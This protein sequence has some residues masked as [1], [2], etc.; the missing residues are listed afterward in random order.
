MGSL[1]RHQGNRLTQTEHPS[2]NWLTLKLELE[3]DK[4]QR[5]GRTASDTGNAL[6]YLLSLASGERGGHT[7]I[8]RVT[9]GTSSVP[10]DCCLEYIGSAGLPWPLPPA[11]ANRPIFSSHSLRC[12]P[13]HLITLSCHIPLRYILSLSP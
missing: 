9:L 10:L 2:T 3:T 7:F 6:M 12:L 11:V 4:A 8:V 13:V 1:L 5:S